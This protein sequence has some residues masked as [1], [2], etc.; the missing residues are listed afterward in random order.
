MCTHMPHVHLHTYTRPCTRVLTYIYMLTL[1]LPPHPSYALPS[2]DYQAYAAHPRLAHTP[3][4][5]P[6]RQPPPSRL[7]PA[8][9]SHLPA[10]PP[11]VQGTVRSLAHKPATGGGGRQRGSACA[12]AQRGSCCQPLPG[13]NPRRLTFLE[14]VGGNSLTLLGCGHLPRE[15]PTRGRGEGAYTCA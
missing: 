7:R 11:T 15:S 3:A 1:V 6:A 10:L 5:L 8:Q 9:P 12:R 13:G 14:G 2:R 4:H